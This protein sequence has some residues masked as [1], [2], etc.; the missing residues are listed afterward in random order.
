MEM[1][2]SDQPQERPKFL[3]VICILSWV[4]IGWALYSALGSMMGGAMTSFQ[5]KEF[6]VQILEMKAE[7]TANGAADFGLFMEKTQNM[8]IILNDNHSAVVGLSLFYLTI[9]AVGVYLMY[10]GKKIGFHLYIAYSI[11]AVFQAYFFMT[12]SDIPTVITMFATGISIIF[13][14]MYSRNLKWMS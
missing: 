3:L 8:A 10:M 6:K 14:V 1:D 5:I 7:L 9:G 13:I 4:N 11:I 2:Y 12:A